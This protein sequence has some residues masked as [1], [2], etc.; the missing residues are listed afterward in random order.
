MG[1]GGRGASRGDH[2]KGT[3]NPRPREADKLCVDEIRYYPPTDAISAERRVA[4]GELDL[5]TDMQS[6]RIAFLRQKMPGYVRTNTYLGTTYIAF[7]N[8][9]KTGYP[10]FRDRRVRQALA[11]SI[12]R[13][14]ITYKL[15]RGG[16]TPALTMVP[17]RPNTPGGTTRR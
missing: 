1:R 11:M 5:N 14:F 3:R 4:S 7:N 8:G 12:D 10:P 16:Q 13:D 15:F 17:F 9:P 2:A 6:N